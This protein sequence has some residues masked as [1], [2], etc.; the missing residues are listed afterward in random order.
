MVNRGTDCAFIADDF[1][2]AN[3]SDG[4]EGFAYVGLRREEIAEE[5]NVC[6]VR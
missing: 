3:R 1:L 4:G 6:G 5:S 2:V